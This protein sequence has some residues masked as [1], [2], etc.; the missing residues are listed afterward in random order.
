MFAANIKLFCMIMLIG[1]L[2][3]SGSLEAYSVEEQQKIAQEYLIDKSEKE[4]VDYIKKESSF[5]PN[6]AV[7]NELGERFSLLF[8]SL[9]LDHKELFNL[10]LSK[11]ADVSDKGDFAHPPSLSLALMSNKLDIAKQLLDLGAEPN[12]SILVTADTGLDTTEKQPLLLLLLNKNLSQA[13]NLVIQYKP[14]LVYSN[15][16][17]KNKTGYLREALASAPYPSL[18]TLEYFLN[19]GESLNTR[20]NFLKETPYEVFL[21][22]YSYKS[23]TPTAASQTLEELKNNIA[24]M[25]FLIEKGAQLEGVNR[26]VTECY[27]PLFVAQFDKDTVEFLIDK[28]LKPESISCNSFSHLSSAAF[29]GHI[30]IF[31]RLLA[32]IPEKKRIEAVKKVL[33]TILESEYS[34]ELRSWVWKNYPT[35]IT[36][37]SVD[38]CSKYLSMLIEEDSSNLELVKALVTRLKADK[39]SL[40]K[41]LKQSLSSEKLDLAD[42]LVENGAE[43]IDINCRCQQDLWGASG[44]VEVFNWLLK[45]K[46]SPFDGKKSISELINTY[47]LTSDQVEQIFTLI[48]KND[49]NNSLVSAKKLLGKY[50]AAT[51]NMSAEQ[52]DKAS[53]RLELLKKLDIKFNELS[54]EHGKLI[55]DEVLKSKADYYLL[56]LLL[57]GTAFSERQKLHYIDNEYIR[58]LVDSADGQPLIGERLYPKNKKQVQD[59][60]NIL[61]TNGNSTDFNPYVFS[62]LVKSKFFYSSIALPMH[63]NLSDN[64]DVFK[65]ASHYSNIRFIWS[66]LKNK[67]IDEGQVKYVYDSMSSTNFSLPPYIDSISEEQRIVWLA[68]QSS[69]IAIPSQFKAF[70]E[71]N[72]LDLNEGL[73]LKDIEGF[74]SDD[75]WDKLDEYIKSKSDWSIFSEK[76]IFESILIEL[77]NENRLN[78]L[79]YLF[80]HGLDIKKCRCVYGDLP[81]DFKVEFYSVL[82]LDTPPNL[83]ELAVNQGNIDLIALLARFKVDLNLIRDN[84]VVPLLYD[85]LRKIDNSDKD[86]FTQLFKTMIEFGTDPMQIESEYNS[87]PLPQRLIEDNKVDLVL[88]LLDKNIPV[89]EKYYPKSLLSL[90]VKNGEIILAKKLLEKG[91]NPLYQD[92]EG[93]TAVGIAKNSD[94]EELKKLF[95]Q[96]NLGKINVGIGD[97][98]KAIKDK[99]VFALKSLLSYPMDLNQ[100]SQDNRPIYPLELA[101]STGDSPELLEIVKLLVEH[102]ADLNKPLSEGDFP[103]QL[104]IKNRLNDELL[105][106]VL[107]KNINLNIKVPNTSLILEGISYSERSKVKLLLNSNGLDIKAQTAPDDQETVLQALILKG[108]EDLRDQVF[109]KMQADKDYL[110]AADKDD[111]TTLHYAALA[112]DK[113]M[114]KNLLKAGANAKKK[115]NELLQPIGL[116]KDKESL[117]ALLKVSDDQYSILRGKCIVLAQE[118]GSKIAQTDCSNLARYMKDHQI[119]KDDILRFYVLAGEFNKALEYENNWQDLGKFCSDVSL[120]IGAAYLLSSNEEKALEFFKTYNEI[121]GQCM[122]YEGYMEWRN[123]LTNAFDRLN[124]GYLKKSTELWSNIQN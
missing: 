77:A 33:K 78:T 62:M 18:T 4:I 101:L 103:I 117:D 114:I 21:K 48:P 1:L 39:V 111:F 86:K 87:A 74:I 109:A 52:L 32:E 73:I 110:N 115:N 37:C 25:R 27:D 119:K 26:V 75:Q 84:K 51:V 19:H 47:Y 100:L 94:N 35:V 60:E 17:K 106:Y 46:V 2:F 10:L 102:G 24:L 63:L 68:Q 14:K 70:L 43:L 85:V 42:Y 29:M 72:K 112:D 65:L 98:I 28:G 113:N 99:N 9:L 50:L 23:I 79:E 6:L 58:Y 71:D 3:V 122:D 93:E 7:N 61:M 95:S 16:M 116:V 31:E 56:W 92:Q 89:Q 40:T 59:L 30:V 123:E 38:I 13:T 57:N 105:V 41:F 91:A 97:I 22:K 83:V 34:S 15:Y 124:P 81:S 90:A 49:K 88:W 121:A 11:G 44:K 107:E 118:E 67:I 64:K 76:I 104:I 55:I 120:N 96:E 5:N 12:P 8:V 53:D 69:K 108:W 66:W 82:K 20:D 45:N 54:N 36:E 80:S